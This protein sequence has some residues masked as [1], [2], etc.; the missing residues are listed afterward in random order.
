MILPPLSPPTS[1]TVTL[2]SKLAASLKIH[3][4]AF[5][6]R[7]D[8]SWRY[9]I[10]AGTEG[11]TSDNG[12]SPSSELHFKSRQEE[13]MIFV[14]NNVGSTKSIPR[15]H[16]GHYVRRVRGN[17]DDLELI[18]LADGLQSTN[19]RDRDTSRRVSSVAEKVEE[20]ASTN[21]EEGHLNDLQGII[22]IAEDDG[23]DAVSVLAGY[24]LKQ[25]QRQ[26][27]QQGVESGV[28]EGQTQEQEQGRDLLDPPQKHQ[29][30][31]GEPKLKDQLSD[32]DVHIN[33]LQEL[34]HTYHSRR[35]GAAFHPLAMH[36]M[37]R[38]LFVQECTSDTEDNTS[39]SSC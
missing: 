20:E 6:R 23:D 28:Q 4:F 8:G 9:A 7:S 2:A 35:R 26:R 14:M 5:V 38:M 16:W 37:K 10:L 19:K 39:Y 15:S 36:D 32:L 17:C 25:K 21:S 13:S 30:Q 33:L 3:D 1:L 24:Q 12:T 11:H 34:Q 29:E 27:K 22:V 31:D 18:E